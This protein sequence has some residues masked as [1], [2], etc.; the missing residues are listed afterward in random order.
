MS[1]LERA[2]EIATEA[3][4]GQLDKAGC[5]YIEHPLRVMA[6]GK[7]L[8]EKIVGVLHDVVEDTNWTFE[9]LAAEGFSAEVIEALRC[10]TKQSESEP[11]DKFIARVKRNPLAV[12]VK[13]NDLSDN[14]DIRR[15]PYLSDKD[16]KR[17]KRY[18]KAYK[19]LTGVPTYSVYA[20]QQQYPNAFLPWSEEDDAT[21]EKMWAEGADAETMATHFKR[22]PSAITTR[23]KRL[24]LVRK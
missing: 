11:Y 19:Q 1:T 2:I 22:K 18:L 4:R 24:G 10:V 13:L 5:D 15:L 20:C 16:V 7:S 8:D 6:A 3:H 14:M 12:A 9:D 21:L 23:L 17:L